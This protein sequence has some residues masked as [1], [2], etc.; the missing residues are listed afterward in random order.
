M[1]FI[2]ILLNHESES[3]MLEL[4]NNEVALVSGADAAATRMPGTN[5]WG[6]KSSG[7]SPLTNGTLACIAE[8][9]IRSGGNGDLSHILYCRIINRD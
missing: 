2:N 6:E 1:N 7:S 8:L 3:K 5:S 9:G 4:N